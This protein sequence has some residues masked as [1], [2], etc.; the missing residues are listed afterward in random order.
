MTT[1]S[2][3]RRYSSGVVNSRPDLRPWCSSSSVGTG[4]RNPAPTRHVLPTR[5]PV[6]SKTFT[7]AF[8][9]NFMTLAVTGESRPSGAWSGRLKRPM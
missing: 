8:A 5:P 2:P 1:S 4:L 3:D 6:S 9:M 7:W